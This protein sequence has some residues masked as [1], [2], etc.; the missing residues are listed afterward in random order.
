MEV[1]HVKTCTPPQGLI[2]KSA[3]VIVAIVGCMQRKF[4]MIKFQT[5]VL[6]LTAPKCKKNLFVRTEDNTQSTIEV[7]KRT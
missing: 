6:K 5:F 7:S 2:A 1:L 4:N 3:F